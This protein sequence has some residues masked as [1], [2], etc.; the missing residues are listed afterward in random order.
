MADSPQASSLA[1]SLERVLRDSRP[2]QAPDALFQ[3]LIDLIDQGVVVLDAGGAT[4]S[5]NAT[6]QQLLDGLSLTLPSVGRRGFFTEAGERLHSVGPVLQALRGEAE[7][8]PMD[9]LARGLRH[10]RGRWLRITARGLASSGAPGLGAVCLLQDITKER[11]QKLSQESS[12]RL[13]RLL[14]EQNL[15]GIIRSRMDGSI[16][17]CNQAF[18]SIIHLDD[19]HQV[20]GYR[21][22]NFYASEADREMNVAELLRRGGYGRELRM[23]CVDGEVIWV[24]MRSTLVEAPADEVGGEILT[25]IIEITE[26]KRFEHTLRVSEERFSTF[27]RHLP[28]MAFIKDAEGRYLYCNEAANRVMGREQSTAVGS[29]PGQIWSKTFAAHLRRNDQRVIESGKPHEFIENVR[30]KDGMHTWLVSKFPILDADG[31]PVLVGGIG[32][33]ITE[34]RNLEERLQQSLKMEAIGR[35]AGGVAHDFNNLLTVISGYGQMALEALG[36]KPAPEKQRTYLQEILHAA[37]RAAGLTGQLLSFSRRQVI[38]PRDL[39]LRKLVSQAERMLR[40]VIGEHI[41]LEVLQPDTPCVVRADAGQ[42]EQVLVN[43]AVNARD[44]M[45]DGGRLRIAITQL[46]RSGL[47]EPSGPCILL[48]VGDTG[49]GMDQM[50]R[51]RLFE[52]FFTSKQ[53]GKGTGLGLATV[54]GIVKQCGGEIL[55]ESEVGKGAKFIIELPLDPPY[56]PG[57][58][59]NPELRTETPNKN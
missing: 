26:Q 15:A 3:S 53:K 18:A 42:L 12:D 20:K 29:A 19:P 59:S 37:Q 27:M 55:V 44:A 9:A 24:L 6:S 21:A 13:Y 2:G 54:Y 8:A 10:P 4:V 45:P 7:P 1:H 30:H 41:E 23:R 56:L 34:R 35:L 38:Q 28:G 25:T 32:L 58:E 31:K 48:E 57:E 36:G 17:E 49:K 5:C 39:D 50:T 46:E 40:R 51:A 33:D 52:P 14:F 47:A 11:Q 16:I 22:A 43:L